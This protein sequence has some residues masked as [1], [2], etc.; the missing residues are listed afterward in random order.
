MQRGATIAA[1]AT[2]NG[3]GGRVTVLSTGHDDRWPA[4]SPPKGGPQGGNGGFVEAS[5]DTLGLTGL[6]R[7]VRP[8]RLGRH[9]SCSTRRDLYI[10]DTNPRDTGTAARGNNLTTGAT[11]ITPN[12]AAP[13]VPA[14]SLPSA[15]TYL[16]ITTGAIDNLTGVVLLQATRDLYVQSALD[17]T[18]INTVTS[19][20]LDAG[21]DMT[22][23]AA[24]TTKGALTLIAGQ[25]RAPAG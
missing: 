19:L 6:D 1:N 7:Y 16:W 8:D 17:T 2:A 22:I 5:G 20:E 23:S 24:V 14:G 9:A 15:T 13:N 10:K 3:N 11:D 4:R 18:G 25:S 12:A 21:R